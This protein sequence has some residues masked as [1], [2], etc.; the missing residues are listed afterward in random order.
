[1]EMHWKKFILGCVAGNVLE[2]YQF[3][4]YGYFAVI[5]GQLFFPLQY[6][7]SALFATFAVFAT[8]A[9][10][11]PFTALIVGYVWDKLGR[12][13]SVIISIGIMSICTLGIGLIPP[14]THI[15]ILAPILLILCRIGQGLSMTGEEI[16]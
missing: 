6:E 10:V 7:Y 8:S 5:I 15:G 16:G 3:I 14:Y 11:R 4:I 1:M 13:I 2:L 9:I 12:R